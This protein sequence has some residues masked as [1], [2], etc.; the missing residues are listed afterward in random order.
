[1]TS[2]QPTKPTFTISRS[3]TD[4]AVESIAS[5]ASIT[6]AV[7]SLDNN[8]VTARDITSSTLNNQR[9]HIRLSEQTSASEDYSSART[10]QPLVA[11]LAQIRDST[12]DTT[13]STTHKHHL[14]SQSTTPKLSFTQQK[15]L[16]Q[17]Q[18]VLIDPTTTSE[19]SN[20]PTSSQKKSKEQSYMDQS[21]LKYHSKRVRVELQMWFSMGINPMHQS[22]ERVLTQGLPEYNIQ[23]LLHLMD[24]DY[25]N[26]Y[27]DPDNNTT[28]NSLRQP[29]PPETTT[30]RQQ[31][32]GWS[33]WL[34]TPNPQ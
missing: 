13:P 2:N 30:D 28:D 27:Q 3:T 16:L 31:S 24:Q 8:A 5:D 18:Q 17:R 21:L 14:S 9:R 7:S 23:P 6:S 20:D 10:S 11:E 1:M 12:Q 19:T 33:R 25:D 32:S 15:V 26:N 34:F 22:L 4:M 29:T